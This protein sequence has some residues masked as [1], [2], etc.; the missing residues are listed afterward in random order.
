MR[1]TFG[2]P[3]SVATASLSMVGVFEIGENPITG[4]SVDLIS[5]YLMVWLIALILTGVCAF[6][7][8]II[9]WQIA[10]KRKID[11]LLYFV[12]SACVTSLA[13]CALAS[14]VPGADLPSNDPERLSFS[15]A[16]LRFVPTFLAGAIVGGTTLWR[17]SRGSIQTKASKP[18]GIG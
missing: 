6:P 18:A 4:F 12:T 15:V 3:I 8:F 9:I 7:A 13:L 10:K 11:S 16:F 1:P 2:Y 17:C 14:F 5:V